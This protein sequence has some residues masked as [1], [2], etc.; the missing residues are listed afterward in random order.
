M[1]VPPEHTRMHT[2]ATMKNQASTET[3]HKRLLHHGTLSPPS[4]ALNLSGVCAT[5]SSPAVV[6]L[7]S[8]Q[9][10]HVCVSTRIKG[11]A[12]QNKHKQ[13]PTKNKLWAFAIFTTA[14]IFG[15]K[16]LKAENVNKRLQN[17]TAWNIFLH[18]TRI[19][20]KRNKAVSNF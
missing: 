4:S 19:Y 17:E 3:Q 1:T 2:R 12:A 9:C 20:K 5:R 8:R 16:N 15:N 18:C 11:T 10:V 7:L 6:L 14:S 13:K